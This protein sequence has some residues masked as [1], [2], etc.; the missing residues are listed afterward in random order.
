[1]DNGATDLKQGDEILVFDMGWNHHFT[2]F[3]STLIGEL[4]DRRLA[5][6]YNTG[7]DNRSSRGKKAESQI[8]GYSL[9]ASQ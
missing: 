3:V 1:M 5:I 9:S 8:E 6:T 2:Y 4:S 7:G